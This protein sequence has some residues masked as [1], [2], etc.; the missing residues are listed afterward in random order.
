MFLGFCFKIL[1][2]SNTFHASALGEGGTISTGTLAP[3]S[4]RCEKMPLSYFLATKL[5]VTVLLAPH[6]PD[7]LKIP[8]VKN[9]TYLTL[10]RLFCVFFTVQHYFCWRI[11]PVFSRYF[12]PSILFAFSD[13]Y[14]TEFAL[15][16][17]FTYCCLRAGDS[18]TLFYT[19]TENSI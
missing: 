13:L 4:K 15:N 17:I 8:F 9:A 11:H 16:N 14:P 12:L 3:E 1:A 5:A 19:S 18:G 2:L 7:F 10:P 6:L